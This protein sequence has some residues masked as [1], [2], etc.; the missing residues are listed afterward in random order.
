MLLRLAGPQLTAPAEPE[1]N[2][3]AQGWTTYRM[4]FV[5]EGA[6]RGALLGFV[7]DVEV[8]EPASL[9]ASFAAA[10]LALLELYQPGTPH[11]RL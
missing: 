2:P 4:L 9:R 11:S 6:A 8:L 10:A 1:R 5:A 7:D 3:G